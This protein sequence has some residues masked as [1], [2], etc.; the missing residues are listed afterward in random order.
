MNHTSRLFTLLCLL[1]LPSSAW[2]SESKLERDFRNLPISARRLTG[3]L[4]WLHGDES[5]ER[6]EQFV[7]KVAEGGNGTFTPESRPHSDWLGKGWYRDLGIC[8]DQAKKHGLTMWIF[9]EKWWPSGMVGGKVPEQFSSKVMNS[10]EVVVDGL[11]TYTGSG[12]GTRLIAVIAGRE[13]P[14]GID[15]T[16][17]ID[18]TGKVSGDKLTWNAPSGKWKVMKF[19]WD[20]GS[21]L[22]DG[23]S[24]DCVDWYIR[25]VY[26]PHYDHFKA[27]FGKTIKGFF[28]DEPET[29]GDWGT[30][31]LPMLKERGVDWK[32]ALVAYKF[33]LA[34]DEQIAAKYQYYDAFAE[35]WGRTL[36]GGLQ[37]WCTKHNTL[38]MGHFLEHDQLYLST[39]VCAGNMFQLQKYS[40][41]GGIDLVCQQMY[42]GQRPFGVYQI[43]KLGS[44]ITH[45]YGK[46]NDIT[47]CEMFG[48]YGQDITYPQMKWLTD[49]MQVRGVNYM[50]PHSFNP[51]AP[52][53]VD[54]PPYFD[55]GGF[56]PRWPLYRVYADY[57]SRLSLML[58][59]G[60]HVCPIALLY[61][62]N[63]SNVG[64]YVTPEAMTTAIQDAAYDCDWLPYDVLEKDININSRELALHNERF[65]VLI[66]PPVEVIPYGTLARVKEFFENGGVVIGYGFA[67]SKSATIGKG[68]SDIMRLVNEIWG[69][70]KPG[71]EVCKTSAAGGMSYFLPENPSPEDLQHVLAVNAKIRPDLEVVRG[72]TNHWLHVLHR[73]KD[74][75]D[76]FFVCNQNWEDQPRRFTFRTHAPGY[77]E[78]WDAM[79][80]EITSIPFTRS[81]DSVDMDLTLQPSESV[82]IVMQ[83]EKR[84]LSVRMDGA[85]IK[86]V[87]IIKVK[88][89]T[90]PVVTKKPVIGPPPPLQGCAWIWFSNENLPGKTFYRRHLQ[91]PEGSKVKSAKFL[92]TCDN[93]FTL[94]INGKQSGKSEGY[95]IWQITATINI[96][97]F[98]RAGDNTF[99]IEARNL[100]NQPNPAG[101]IG[102]CVIKLDNGKNIDLPIDLAWKT[103][104][105]AADGWQETEFDDSAWREPVEVGKYGDQ[106]WGNVD[107]AGLLTLSPVKDTT[108]KGTCTIPA[109]LKLKRFRVCLEADSLSPEAAANITVNGHYAGGF[110]G[111]PFR[112]DVTDHLKPGANSIIVAPFAPTGLRLTVYPK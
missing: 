55:N 105:N 47:M 65:K 32:N 51:R 38:S 96:A 7:N 75:K 31:V 5:K 25:K 69:N 34:G 48:A 33:K 78:C 72:E 12:Y 2:A 46:K 20:R 56:E 108:F 58:S 64:K 62:G 94:F 70:S 37:D 6:L 4:F 10:S 9:D 66:V 54:C 86:P 67:P 36:Y 100:D 74:G 45:A 15:S 111:K 11:S 27:D 50:V 76:I 17:L 104:D 24:Q 85:G 81:G 107:G 41:M 95:D 29:R 1:L 39:G 63:S 103:S 90:S 42:P 112:L 8:L 16:S 93:E 53:D 60:K 44:S 19:T 88:G 28:Y 61:L 101:L 30:E 87:R 68:S 84:D 91:I 59:G 82:M 40:G 18:L 77:P 97:K 98:L 14:G 22:V 49:Q 57:T 73:V 109:S 89:S 102:K 35:A 43:P 23:A 79:R 71:L 106:P 92:I 99:A 26:Q 3:P 83:P 110:I 13:T 80:N 21:G 52:Y